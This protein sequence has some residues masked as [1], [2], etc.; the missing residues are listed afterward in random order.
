LFYVLLFWLSGDGSSFVRI[1]ECY[2]NASGWAEKEE[3]ISFLVT[4]LISHAVVSIIVYSSVLGEKS[5]ELPSDIAF[6]VPLTYAAYVAR[7]VESGLSDAADLFEVIEPA[8]YKQGIHIHFYS[9]RYNLSTFQYYRYLYR[10][11]SAGPE[12]TRHF[13]FWTIQIFPPGGKPY[14]MLILIVIVKNMFMCNFQF[15]VLFYLMNFPR[16]GGEI[17][18]AQ[19]RKCSVIYDTALYIFLPILFT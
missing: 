3:M 4:S 13:P 6:D 9:S 7:A 15:K 1:R 14:F 8:L 17:C 11:Y 12:V 19:K 16:L 5:S 18:L 10:I 2:F